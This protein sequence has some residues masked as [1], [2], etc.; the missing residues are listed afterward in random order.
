M[1]MVIHKDETI[2]LKIKPL[3]VFRQTQKKT[4]LIGIIL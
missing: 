2:Q 1:K 4:T 3:F